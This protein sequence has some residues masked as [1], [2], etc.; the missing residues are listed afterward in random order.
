MS[1][2]Y[3]DAMKKKRRAEEAA[4][5]NR[6]RSSSDNNNNNNSGRPNNSGN[7]H[8]GP[9]PAGNGTGSASR[10]PAWGSNRPQK[11]QQQ[12]RASAWGG[13]AT[14]GS[15][16]NTN[17]GPPVSNNKEQPTG[18]LPSGSTWGKPATTSSKSENTTS[19]WTTI[20]KS[21]SQQ[22]QR[23]QTVTPTA[24]SPTK[25]HLSKQHPTILKKK[26][27]SQQ[28]TQ[29]SK[30]LTSQQQ[31]NKHQV[32]TNSNPPKKSKNPKPKL[33]SMSIGDMLLPNQKKQKKTAPQQQQ[34]YNKNK[35]KQQQQQQQPKLKVDSAQD[36]PA[37][38]A[39]TT[40]R[41]APSSNPTS[42][43]VGWG[44]QQQQ[45][46]Q[47][48]KNAVFTS[49]PPPKTGKASIV[50][51]NKSSSSNTASNS[52]KKKKKKAKANND[53]SS[54]ESSLA[55]FFQPR[56]RSTSQGL[57]NANAFS[58]EQ[59]QQQ[60]PHR[61]LEGEE[62]QL[63]RLMQERNVYQKKGRQRVAP[64]KKKFTALKKKVLQER[65]DKWRELHPET[66]KPTGALLSGDDD[67]KR[68]T[69]TNVVVPFTSICI[70]NYTTPE[71]LE[72]DD[73]YE[74][75]IENLKVMAT[76]IG[77]VREIHVPR[78]TF[79]EDDGG[80][81]HRNDDE[82]HPIFVQ[83]QQESDAA[84]AQGCWNDLVVGGSKLGVV[85][86]A[87]T[88]ATTEDDETP[89]SERVLLV[90]MARHN[91]SKASPDAS[92]ATYVEVFLQ[93]VLT[94]DDYE[95]NDCLQ[96]SLDDL[97]KV[98]ELHGRLQSTK[99]TDEKDG[100][101]VLTYVCDVA[102]ARD[103]ATNLCK[104][105]VG[106]KPL[107]AFLNEPER[108][109][110]TTDKSTILLQNILNE[111]DLE[112][113]DCLSETLNDIRELCVRYGDILD[114][115]A[116][117][118]CVR[119]TFDGDS[120]IGEKASIELNGLVLGGSVVAASL[121]DEE[122]K[123]IE[124]YNVLT[125]DDLEDEDCLE[126][127][128]SDIRELATKYGVVSS[129]EVMPVGGTA[130][131]RIHFDG[132]ASVASEAA[133]SFD[134]MV[135][136]GQICSAVYEGETKLT[137]KY[138]NGESSESSGD[139]RKSQDAA[140][141]DN[142]DKKARTDDKAPLYS[143]DKLIPERFA[144]MKRVPKVSNTPGPREYAATISDE[145]VKP[146]LVEMLGELMRLQKRAIEDKN[147]KTRR[148]L[149]M[150]LREVA[151]GIRSHKVKMVIMANNLDQYG[152]IDE[153]LQ[154]IIDLAKSEDVPLFFEFSKRTLGKA[155]GK[156]IKIAVVGVQSA[157][158]A[159]QQFK[160]LNAIGA[161]M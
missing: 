11:Q 96:E 156:N 131:I 122:K 18:N 160:K 40:S 4:A 47:Q 52:S 30:N 29:P 34:Q 124:L 55:S 159:H 22:Q 8:R 82:E 44:V 116:N 50:N 118:N 15:A 60:H 69:T 93:K 161:R 89:W 157:D 133:K 121:V 141:S 111:D 102:T 45:Q 26:N 73:E 56:A 139:K 23:Q 3:A 54:A 115:A 91:D 79:V 105:V 104:T 16:R 19:A 117:G 146:L 109:D 125:K 75:I 120:T 113:G 86:L 24:R 140:A 153:K 92:M 148:R 38:G 72:D 94:E 53:A 62:H 154:E 137:T 129:I 9:V 150:G 83:F 46:Q 108:K 97:S 61:L 65:L 106:G 13:A 59:Q 81:H 84:A 68:G 32:A 87:I 74:E 37:L 25:Q 57:G 151:R 43:K 98:A 123:F 51:N 100:N 7:P 132:E 143:G 135:I 99:A 33:K 80:E 35:T 6:S 67:D 134:G 147:S 119:V 76:K 77:P 101:V 130:S 2:S 10:P 88:T 21:K 63:L 136:G 110:A 41:T 114:V 48:Q 142:T 158:G 5:A 145:R 36:F 28:Q 20:E 112:D 1:F 42:R 39:P 14:T 155:V 107:H 152:V 78:R 128:L 27:P 71:E 49:A 64:R 144:E 85:G 17:T 90:E 58:S 70:Y 103:I 12:P 66:T 126:E 127:S 138:L 95:D 149:V 31:H